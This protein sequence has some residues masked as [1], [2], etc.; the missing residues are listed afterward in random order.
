MAPKTHRFTVDDQVM[1]DLLRLCAQLVIPGDTGVECLAGN[2][3][4]PAVLALLPNSRLDGLA[5]CRH[6]TQQGI[7]TVAVTPRLAGDLFEDLAFDRAQGIARLGG[8][9]WAAIL[10]GQ[11]IEIMCRIAHAAQP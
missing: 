5:Q 9:V 3:I 7:Q 6:Y 4:A 10:R 8:R 2:G 1:L 11:P